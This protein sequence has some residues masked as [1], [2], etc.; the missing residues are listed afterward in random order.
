MR[1]MQQVFVLALLSVVYACAAARSTPVDAQTIESAV[2]KDLRTFESHLN[3]GQYD[4]ALSFYAKDAR[5]VAFENGERRYESWAALRDTYAKLP[6]YGQGTFRYADPQVTAIDADHA[7]LATAFWTS[8]GHPDK[9]GYFQ[10][11]GRLTALMLRTPSG[12]AML[13]IHASTL[14]PKDADTR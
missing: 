3:A 14:P 13:K 6:S 8:F 1:T 10:F 4:Q 11:E 2:I 7:Y 12:W 5:F 9:P